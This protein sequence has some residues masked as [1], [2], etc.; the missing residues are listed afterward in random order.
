MTQFE[1]E[2]DHVD[3]AEVAGGATEILPEEDD[4]FDKFDTIL[5]EKV[6]ATMDSVPKKIV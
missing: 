3:L 4:A 5:V 1:K 2:V 6:S